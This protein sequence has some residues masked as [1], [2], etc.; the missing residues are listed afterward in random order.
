M[1]PIVLIISS[2]PELIAKNVTI[3]EHNGFNTIISSNIERAKKRIC[4]YPPHCVLTFYN[5]TDSI[6]ADF[7]DSKIFQDLPVIVFTSAEDFFIAKDSYK[8]LNVEILNIKDDSEK[9]L[10]A[11]NKI[12]TKYIETPKFVKINKKARVRLK[13]KITEINEAGFSFFSDLR[14]SSIKVYPIRSRFFVKLG[15]N[16]PFASLK[17]CTTNKNLCLSSFIGLREDERTSIRKWIN[18]ELTRQN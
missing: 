9:I 10:D 11:V 5:E 8:E 17:E 15:F 18:S 3:L 6:I 2:I 12:I 14:F 1:K 4:L 7:R 16:P 13:V